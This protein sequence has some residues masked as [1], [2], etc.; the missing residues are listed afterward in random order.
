MPTQTTHAQGASFALR[1]VY[2]AESK[3]VAYF[4]ISAKPGETVTL[5]ADVI[6]EANTTKT[7]KVS[8]NDAY[9][10]YAGQVAYDPAGPRD[11]SAKYRLTELTQKPQTVKLNAGEQRRVTFTI[12]V[13]KNG[14]QGELAGSFYAIDTQSYQ[15]STQGKMTVGNKYAMYS[16]IILRTSQKYVTPELKMPKLDMGMQ[17]GSA[18]ILATLQNIKPQMFGKMNISAKVYKDD[19]KKAIISREVNNYSMAPNSH[20]AFGVYSSHAFTEGKYT[21]DLTAKSGVKTWHFRKSMTVTQAKAD[22]V[23]R[24]ASLKVPNR[25]PWWIL[26]VIGL[27]L[28]IIILLLILLLKRRKKE[29]E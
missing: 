28:L 8:I 11:N 16:A 15:K 7:I 14:F 22:K 13:P 18:A 21:I 12:P 3:Q 24:A 23:N 20:F 4:N 10:T 29:D 6:N 2:N 17:A 25:F 9:T 26:I 19:G 1:P 27:L 5:A